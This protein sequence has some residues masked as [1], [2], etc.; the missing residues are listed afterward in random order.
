MCGMLRARRLG[1]FKREYEVETSSGPPV[2]VSGGK[3]E[4]CTF[5]LDGVGYRIERDGRKRF[6]LTGPNGRIATADRET[7][8]QWAIKAQGG[9]AKLVRPSIWRSGWELHQRGSAQ[10][11]IRHDG[12][13]S[14][15]YPADLPADL[16]L[17]VRM[18]AFYVV[19]VLFE[20]AAAAAAAS[21]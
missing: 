1:W 13:F 2:T 9:N 4:A 16:D 18:L 12:A 14:R 20:R 21:G 19:L 15:W 7:G 10:G 8:R 11:T 17:S 6:V 5:E 3:R